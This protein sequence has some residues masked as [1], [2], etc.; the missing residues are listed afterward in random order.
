M[1]FPLLN[2]VWHGLKT[3]L[4]LLLSGKPLITS[5]VIETCSHFKLP[6]NIVKSESF[7]KPD[8]LSWHYLFSSW[9]HWITN[10]VELLETSGSIIIFLLFALASVCQGSFLVSVKMISSCW[11]LKF[12]NQHCFYCLVAGCFISLQS[13]WLNSSVRVKQQILQKQSIFSIFPIGRR[14]FDSL[15]HLFCS[16][17]YKTS[18]AKCPTISLHTVTAVLL[19]MF[20]VFFATIQQNRLRINCFP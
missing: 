4:I 20:L 1:P 14:I 6:S 7:F 3:L 9:C 5:G 11:Y 10:S 19:E 13:H 8:P 16:R 18:K 2:S 12:S 17:Y 15:Y